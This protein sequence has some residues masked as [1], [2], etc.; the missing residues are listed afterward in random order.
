MVLN[1][2]NVAF[3]RRRRWRGGHAV[4][5]LALIGPWLFLMFAVI[6]NFGLYM[7]AGIS[8]A[9]AARAAALEAG[10]S[11]SPLNLTQACDIARQEM[12]YLP[13]ITV[14]LP[15]TGAP[16]AI[17]MGNAGSSIVALDNGAKTGARVQIVYTLPPLFLLPGMLPPPTIRRIAEMRVLE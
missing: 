4:V 11:S 15:C 6:L 16:L 9:N 14:G 1:E 8:V 10:R 2:G 3:V 7:Y 17:T 5:E 12:L 13:G